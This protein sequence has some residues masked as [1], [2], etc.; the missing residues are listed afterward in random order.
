MIENY[1]PVTENITKPRLQ[2]DELFNEIIEH[3]ES[4]TKKI[5]I[6]A[7][8]GIGKSILAV[9]LMNYFSSKG[10]HSMVT[11]PLNILV[12][13]YSKD[14]SPKYLRTIKGK[15]YYQCLAKP[16]SMCNEGFCES[17]ICSLNPKYD[18]NCGKETYCNDCVC[19]QCLFKQE[20]KAFK[21]S[22]MG[23]TN[24]TMFQ[25][26]IHNEPEFIIID[27]C[28]ETENFIRLFT[29][30]KVPEIIDFEDFEDHI[31]SLKDWIEYN[32]HQIESYKINLKKSTNELDKSNLNKQIIKLTKEI[33]RINFLL[34][35]YEK[36][37]EPW[38][39]SIDVNSKKTTYEP[40]TTHRILNNLLE[41]KHVIQMSATPQKDMGE[42]YVSV[43]AESPFDKNLRSWINKP[44]GKMSLRFREANIP[45]L[46]EFLETLEGK[47]VVHCVSYGVAN[48]VGKGLIQK[49][50]IPLTQISNN[51]YNE[52]PGFTRRNDIVDEF[53]HS[54][55]PNQILLSVKMDRGVNYFEYDIVNNVIAVIPWPN[56][57][58]P[59]TKN[60]N[61]YLGK[62]WQNDLMANTIMQ[63]YGRINRNNQKK[64]M[65]Y[66]I[67]SNFTNWFYKNKKYFHKWFLE[68]EIK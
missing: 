39:F 52:Q 53:K 10:K 19:V 66:I 1:F 55:N 41:D 58:D 9:S 61:K 49:G 20:L 63:M 32:T 24:F 68:A 64:T 15:S 30:I 8:T 38:S 48:M 14:F 13:Q 27:E 42:L 29:K 31:I 4:G 45:K 2:Q 25:L 44:L 37:N 17:N 62:G 3:I 57:V 50:I 5:S 18:R 59:L 21:K 34:R 33:D 56:P 43:N 65:T 54:N 35:D 7:P 22:E 12:D 16:N 67:D 47:T 28:D 60:K 23:N 36:H 46:I 6:C 51:E 11:S 26:N 40:I